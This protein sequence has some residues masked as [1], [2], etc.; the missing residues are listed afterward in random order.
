MSGK[1]SILSTYCTKFAGG[2]YLALVIWIWVFSGLII[3]TIFSSD[4]T[5]FSKPLFLTYFS[6]SF[7]LLHFIL[8]IVRFVYNK[9]KSRY[10]DDSLN[11]LHE[12]EV[13]VN[14]SNRYSSGI[15]IYF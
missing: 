10:A 5:K 15:L 3:Q 12:S 8:P 6:T 7:F 1:K 4:D 14:K 9:I 2:I 11:K 13:E